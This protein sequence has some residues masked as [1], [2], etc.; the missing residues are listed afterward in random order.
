MQAS[1][2]KGFFIS[3]VIHAVVFAWLV[4]ATF[5]LTGTTKPADDFVFNMVDSPG[6]PFQMPGPPGPPAQTAQAQQPDAGMN[7]L[8]DLNAPDIPDV[9]I[10]PV[11]Q[12]PA[13]EPPPAAPAP[14][15]AERPTQR[16][17]E[18]ARPMSY[19][20]FLRQ[21]RDGRRIQ[22]TAT[23]STRSSTSRRPA[24]RVNIQAGNIRQSLG[25]ITTGTASGGGGGGGGGMSSELARY[26]GG[27]RTRID[28]SWE[29]PDVATSGK[30]V[31]TVEFTVSARGQISAR[32]V[33]KSSG[34]P[35]FDSSA[36]AAFDSLG[37]V[38]VPPGGARTFQL[39]FTLND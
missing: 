20:E 26:A 6:T 27:L 7:P 31:V 17:R 24:A 4:V 36:L 2:R 23:T 11:P 16:P 29:K 9:P 21:T 5:F 28:A 30:I 32:R 3:A 22:N 38:G 33:L 18:N 39:D 8:P 12:P 35:S 15:R 25:Q 1:E 37:Y 34:F 13:P 14:P 19:E 10:E